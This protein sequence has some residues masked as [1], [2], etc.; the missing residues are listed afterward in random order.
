MKNKTYIVQIDN[1][2]IRS[3]TSNE[4]IHIG[5]VISDENWFGAFIKGGKVTKVF[6]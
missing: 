5:S 2:N 6:K 1:K 4:I 3:I